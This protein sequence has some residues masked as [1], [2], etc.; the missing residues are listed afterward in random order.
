MEAVEAVEAVEVEVEV[1]AVVVVAVSAAPFGELNSQEATMDM[2]NTSPMRHSDDAQEAMRDSIQAMASLIGQLQRREQALEDLVRQQL[3]LLQQAANRADQ[4]VTQVVQDALPRLTQLS[5]QALTQSLEPAVTRFNKK[6]VDADQT[7]EHATYRYAQAQQSLEAMV[8]RRMWIGL[9]VIIIGALLCVGGA[10]YALK[11][12][13]S[14]LAEAAQRRAEIAYLDRV[15]RAD[16]AP[17]DANR[18]CAVVEKKT[19]QYGDKG[20]Y[21]VIALRPSPAR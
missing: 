21:R 18:L 12:A 17:C 9:S 11:A 3:Q 19:K 4:R 6:M 20:Q 10:A 2:Q 14:G 7:L 16:L 15:A 8:T 13:Q 5:N 1:E